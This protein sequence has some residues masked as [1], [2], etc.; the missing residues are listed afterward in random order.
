MN[1]KFCAVNG[2]KKRN[3]IKNKVSLVDLECKL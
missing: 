1:G 3:K 2:Y